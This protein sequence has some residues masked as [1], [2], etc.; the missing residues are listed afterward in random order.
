M[1]KSRYV[2]DEEIEQKVF[3]LYNT[4][5][6]SFVLLNQPKHDLWEKDCEVISQDSPAFYHE[7]VEKGFIIEEELDEFE[8]IR[9]RKNL[10]RQDSRMYQV[11]INTTLDCNLNCWYCYEKKI[12]GSRLDDE[13]IEAI[14]KNISVEYNIERYSSL[15]VSFF[16]GE[17]FLDFMAIQNIL[18]Y[19]K[20]F[21]K[22]HKIELIADFTTNATL[23]TPIH[24]EY[25]KNYRCHFQITLDGTKD[26][27][28][29]IKKDI[30]KPSED[31]YGKTIEALRLI[32]ENIPNRWVAVR[33]N[34]DNRILRNIKEILDNISFL[35][36]KTTY[37]ILKK[38]WQI[39][40][41]KVD[42]EALVN[43][44]QMILDRKYVL[45]YY[46]MPKGCV[47]FAERRRMT[48][49]NYDGKVFKCSTISFEEN[50]TLGVV[51]K[52]TG[53]VSWKTPKIVPWFK[54]ELQDECKKCKWFPACLGPCNK[55]KLIYK[56]K[57]ICTFD[58]MNLDFKEY[59]VYLF[60]CQLVRNEIYNQ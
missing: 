29:T 54:E 40:T 1:K 48:L 43:A 53:I 51:D 35:N 28:N 16:G 57:F 24:I 58:A 46:I 47:C 59:L 52:N 31:S 15:K 10:M 3:L 60:K 36:P 55:Q 39:E 6:N 25:L 12:K 34:F 56:D 19:S 14:K 2:I 4:F 30:F 5:S 50:E 9:Y 18:D 13:T 38:V 23:I 32:N 45:D 37:I 21:C 26:I 44:M 8:T 42:K 7:L 20:A 11:M 27:H 17:P 22:E 41:E 49:F 33:I